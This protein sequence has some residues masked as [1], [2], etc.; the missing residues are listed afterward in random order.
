MKGEVVATVS[1]MSSRI[2]SEARRWVRESKKEARSVNKVTTIKI[3][4]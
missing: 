4:G 2:S 3:I 1:R